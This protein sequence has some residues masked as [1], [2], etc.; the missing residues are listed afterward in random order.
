MKLLRKPPKFRWMDR[1][2]WTLVFFAIFQ[3]KEKEKKFVKTRGEIIEA[4]STR[5][6][7]VLGCYVIRDHPEIILIMEPWGLDERI[8]KKST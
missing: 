3:Y 6:T 2:I 1:I 8:V 4:A 5:S 7:W